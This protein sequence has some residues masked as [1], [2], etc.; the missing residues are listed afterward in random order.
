MVVRREIDRKPI[1]RKGESSVKYLTATF[2]SAFCL[3]ACNSG[4]NGPGPGASGT[5]VYTG[6][7]AE[8]SEYTHVDPVY[9]HHCND[10]QDISLPNYSPGDSILPELPESCQGAGGALIHWFLIKKTETTNYPTTPCSQSHH[11]IT[12]GFVLTPTEHVYGSQT[13]AYSETACNGQYTYN[14]QVT[15]MI[16]P[17]ETVSIHEIVDTTHET[18]SAIEFRIQTPTLD[19]NSSVSVECDF[20]ATGEWLLLHSDHDYRVFAASGYIWLYSGHALRESDPGCP[21]TRNY[22][23]TNKSPIV[24]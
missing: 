6:V 20:N 13:S 23:V 22:R 7:T 18:V 24:V 1:S 4:P 11:T 15:T 21:D 17:L 2:F 19:S 14:P 16:E 9:H 3:W 12:S 10:G 5:F 8:G